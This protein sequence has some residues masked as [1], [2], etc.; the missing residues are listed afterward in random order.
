MCRVGILDCDWHY[1]DVTDD[2]IRRLKPTGDI[3]HQT[4]GAQSLRDSD[5]YFSWLDSAMQ[6]LQEAE[7]DLI[8][9]QAGADAYGADAY[10][11]DTLGGLHTNEELSKRDSRV[12]ERCCHDKLPIAWNLAG[13]YQRAAV[14]QD[15]T[16]RFRND[17]NPQLR[18]M[19][20]LPNDQLVD[21]NGQDIR[22]LNTA[23]SYLQANQSLRVRRN[24]QIVTIQQSISNAN[25]NSNQLGWTFGI[26]N[27]AVFISSLTTNG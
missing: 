11:D 24:G 25:L 7:V 21:S 26:R 16:G 5:H 20:I 27:N 2:I 1:G 6:Q 9:Y 8:L 19:G 4:N 15:G 14:G 18:G 12:F 17:V 23:N 13:G 22:D 3:V 10:I